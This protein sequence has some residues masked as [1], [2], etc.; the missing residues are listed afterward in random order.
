MPLKNFTFSGDMDRISYIDQVQAAS[1]RGELDRERAQLI[2]TFIQMLAPVQSLARRVSKV[3]SDAIKEF[4]ALTLSIRMAGEE[5][6]NAISSAQKARIGAQTYAE[7]QQVVSQKILTGLNAFIA[8][9]DHDK[10]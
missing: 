9:V 4:E 8:K 7:F 1:L 10:L 2:Q 3:T 5:R 6:F